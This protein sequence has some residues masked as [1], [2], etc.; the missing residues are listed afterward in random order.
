LA[1]TVVDVLNQFAA[2]DPLPIEYGTD[3]PGVTVKLL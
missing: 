1:A 2:F 3:A